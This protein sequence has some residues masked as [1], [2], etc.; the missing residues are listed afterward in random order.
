MGYFLFGGGL[1]GGLYG[2][3]HGTQN[4]NVVAVGLLFFRLQWTVE[5]EGVQIDA[6]IEMA[7]IWRR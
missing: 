4:K 2:F 1:E 5:R 7:E 3:L 6:K